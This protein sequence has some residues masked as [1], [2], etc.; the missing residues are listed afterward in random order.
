MKVN[1]DKLDREELIMLLKE[2]A[3]KAEKR[4]NIRYPQDVLPHVQR[5]RK[6]EQECFVVLILD[7]GHN[8]I[9]V[10]EVSKGL[11]N[12]TVVHPREVFREA[13]KKNATAVILVHNHP[14]GNVSPSSE[15]VDVKNRMKDAGEIIGIAVLDNM[16]ISEDSYYSF[17]EKG[18]LN[19]R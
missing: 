8:V 17:L 1:Y 13:I 19:D 9:K 5:F 16:V 12:R 7:G 15:D 2:V 3:G 6:K 11:V 4:N 18:V 10:H 14:S